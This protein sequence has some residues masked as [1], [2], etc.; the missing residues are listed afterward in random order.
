MKMKRIS[1]TLALLALLLNACGSNAAP[2]IDPVQVQASAMAAASTMIALT[3][4]AIPTATDTPLP[5]PTPLPSATPIQLPT[6]P[7]FPTASAPTAVPQGNQGSCVH[8]L[9]MGAAGP[10]H[11]IVIKNETGGTINLSL[12]LYQPNAF[13][14]CGSL[15]YSGVA[16]NE[17][18]SVQLPSGYW[19]AYAWATVKGKSFTVDGSFYVQPAQTLKLELCVRANNIIFEQAC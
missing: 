18:I 1:F 19:Y 7:Q 5:S 3:K 11:P 14:E 8:P 6:F 10:K 17:S 2:P 16:K 9:D 12:N 4:A 13:G 15:S